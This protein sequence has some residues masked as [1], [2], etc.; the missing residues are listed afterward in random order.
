LAHNGLVVHR[1]FNGAWDQFIR[2]IDE[3]RP[4]FGDHQSICE[5]VMNGGSPKQ[6]RARLHAR[7][8]RL[9]AAAGLP[10]T[11]SKQILADAISIGSAVGTLCPCSRQ[12]E[13]KLEI[14][15]ENICSRWHRDNFAGRAIVSY[16]GTVGTEYTHNTNVNFW[17][18]EH[19][20]KNEHVIRDPA[21]VENIAVGDILFIKGTQFPEGSTGLVHKSPEKRY[22]ED[23][24]I[25]NRLV[26]KVDVMPADKYEGQDARPSSPLQMASRVITR[27]FA[28][29]SGHA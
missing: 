9:V 25:M 3:A 24:R 12:L 20:G 19:C 22:H 6:L 15:G 27:A 26:F 14:F 7:A 5:T 8:S 11:L 2:E 28:K 1:P 18:L 10:E 29:R 23:G 16:T 17:E 21:L 4:R 13:L